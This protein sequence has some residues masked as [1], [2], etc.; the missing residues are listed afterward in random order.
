MR[1][2]EYSSNTEKTY[3]GWINR[4]I[5]F[6][7]SRVPESLGEVDVASF[8]EHSALKRKVSGATQAQAL[9]AHVFFFARVLEKPLEGNWPY[10]NILRYF[11]TEKDC[12]P[13]TAIRRRWN[14]KSSRPLLSLVSE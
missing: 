5:L 4:F 11:I 13:L 6:H 14:T 7:T 1:I 2:P 3:L 9:N 8:L 10:L 12:I